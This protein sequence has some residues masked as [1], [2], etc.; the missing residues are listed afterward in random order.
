MTTV[1]I[2]PTTPADSF[3]VQLTPEQLETQTLHLD[4]LKQRVGLPGLSLQQVPKNFDFN[5][6]GTVTGRIASKDLATA[7]APKSDRTVVLL[8]SSFP[9]TLKHLVM[10]NV[11]EYVA[12]SHKRR[13]NQ[14]LAYHLRIQKKWNKRF[15]TDPTFSVTQLKQLALPSSVFTQ[16][17]DS[18]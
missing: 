4:I 3:W 1:R 13:H 10:T 15:K 7:N 5:L 8:D 16:I 18:V 6:C 9:G 12:K 2:I 14:T 11:I 17:K